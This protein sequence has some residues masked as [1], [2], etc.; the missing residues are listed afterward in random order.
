MRSTIDGKIDD[1]VWS[2]AE[3]LD[4]FIQFEPYNLR[5]IRQ[6]GGTCFI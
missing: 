1:E 6:N 2:K 3:P 5:R 4:D